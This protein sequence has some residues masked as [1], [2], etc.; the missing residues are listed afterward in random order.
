[1]ENENSPNPEQQEQTPPVEEPAPE[2]PEQQETPPAEQPEPPAVPT[3]SELLAQ[4]AD[5]QSQYQTLLNEQK[6]Q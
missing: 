6:A 5:Y 4:S 1:M 3:L 2:N